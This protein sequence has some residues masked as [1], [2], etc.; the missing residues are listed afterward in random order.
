MPANLKPKHCYATAVFVRLGM[1]PTAFMSEHLFNAL[2]DVAGPRLHASVVPMSFMRR[3]AAVSLIALVVAAPRR[4]AAD[5]SDP[6]GGHA[7]LSPKEKLRWNVIMRDGKALVDDEHWALATAKFSEAVKL[8][9]RPEAYIWKGFT[10]EKLGHLTIA[11]AM[12]SQAWSEAKANDL[13]QLVK[14]SEEALILLGKKMPLIVVQ[15]PVGVRARVS[16]DGASIAMTPEGIGVNPG[17]RSL[18]VSAPGRESFHIQ[19]KAEE[20]QVYRFEAPLALLPPEP[21]APPVEGM[22]GCGACSV[23]SAGGELLPS[24]LATL[25]VLFIAKRRRSRRRV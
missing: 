24:F 21:P 18:D 20:G 9:P 8:D 6:Y 14:K 12:Y 22:R 2:D 16:I 17:S 1:S 19:V 11:K 4:V 10:E 23:G 13:P 7:P 3:L 15:L 25:A 5:E